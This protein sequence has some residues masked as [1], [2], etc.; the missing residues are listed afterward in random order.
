MCPSDTLPTPIP[1]WLL[2]YPEE[3]DAPEPPNSAEY[4][5]RYTQYW[6]ENDLEWLEAAPRRESEIVLRYFGDLLNT[7]QDL[8]KYYDLLRGS[9]T[10]IRERDVAPLTPTYGACFGCDPTEGFVA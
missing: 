4:G 8:Q 2:D 3:I 10:A 1:Y 7:V 5:Y 6:M 9:I